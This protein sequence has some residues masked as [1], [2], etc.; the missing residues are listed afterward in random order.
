MELFI[1]LVVAVGCFFAIRHLLTDKPSSG[2]GGSKPDDHS[3][4][5]KA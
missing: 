3:K 1:T 2:S 4:S 5:D